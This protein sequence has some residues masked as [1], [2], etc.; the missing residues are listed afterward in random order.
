M[1]T[2]ICFML[3][4]FALVV[5]IGNSRQN[6][7]IQRKLDLVFALA[8]NYLNQEKKKEEEKRDL[9]DGGKSKFRDTFF[10]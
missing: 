6:D 3:A 4:L 1:M 5:S 9:G 2:G 7:I 8:Q 10:Q